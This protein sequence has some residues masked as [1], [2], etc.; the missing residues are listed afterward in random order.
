M[1]SLSHLLVVLLEQEQSQAYQL[2]LPLLS[3]LLSSVLLLQP[4]MMTIPQ[5]QHLIQVVLVVQAVQVV[6]VELAVLVVP[7]L[8]KSL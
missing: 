2:L 7:D 4:M 3:V 5:L 1:L 6:P 8:Y